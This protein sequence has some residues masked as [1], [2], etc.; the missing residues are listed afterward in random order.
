MTGDNWNS[1][2]YHAMQSTFL[3]AF[4]FVTAYGL[5]AIVLFRLF[6]GI[7]LYKF[8]SIPDKVV[9]RSDGEV[10]VVMDHKETDDQ[11]AEDDDS[12]VRIEWSEIVNELNLCLG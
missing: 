6:T 10:K 8:S 5:G 3:G 12:D 4:F 7:L 1:I 9:Q 11:H 2:M